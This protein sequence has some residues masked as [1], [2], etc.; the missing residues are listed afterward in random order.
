MPRVVSLFLP[1][2]PTDRLRR[3]SGD[4]SPPHE[5]PLV[6]IGRTGRRRT[7]AA[8]DTNAQALGLTRGMA[9]AKAQALVPGLVVMDADPP[10]DRQ[11]L[12]RLALW[13]LQ[14]ISPVVAADPPDGL[15]IDTTG[16]DHLHGGEE[17][18]LT[19]IVQRLAASGVE[20]RAAVADTWGAAHAAARFVR[21]QTTVVPAGR[22]TAML[23]PM[24]LAALRLDGEIVTGLR[25]LGFETVGDLMDQPRAPLVLRFGPE[26][27]RRLEQAVGLVAEPVEPIRSPELVE[28]R[29]VF[30]E[31]IGAAETIARYTGKL[32]DALCLQLEK[33]G[34]GARRLDLLLHRVDDTL[35]FIRVGMAQPVRDPKR[36]TRLLRDKIETIDPGFGI[37]IMVLV[38]I[39]TEALHDNQAISSLVAPPE[40]DVSDLVDVLA[41]RVGGNRLYR[42]TP[43]QSDVPER[44][45]ARVPALAPETGATWEGD[46]PRPPRLLPRPEPVET[47][48]LLPDHPPVWFTWRGVRRRV[49]RADGPERIRGEWWKRDAEM[50]TVRDYFR[51]EDETGERYWLFRSGDGERE[52][53]GSH[54]WFLHGIF[55]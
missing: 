6:L 26:I 5:A 4:A 36:L 42:F 34:L 14:R 18:M 54:R 24:P 52:D 23:R 3:K 16:T 21:R 32:V 50:T 29:R 35:Q 38:A 2:W 51:V 40:P 11:G 1:R 13:A 28:V 39:E 45:V 12:E 41:N 9:V 7:I 37:E 15:V 30:G 20:A 48:A 43:V 44:S 33:R 31:P 17:M 10:A 49:K 19:A 47:M 27:G 25:S 55:A 8:L 22:G 53:S 46:W